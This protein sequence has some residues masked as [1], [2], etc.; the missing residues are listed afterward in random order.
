M[1]QWLQFF[2]IPGCLKVQMGHFTLLM[3]AI[4]HQAQQTH[5][6]QNCVR[7][8]CWMRKTQLVPL[9]FHSL[10]SGV[11]KAPGS[12]TCGGQN[13]TANHTSVQKMSAN[14]DKLLKCWPFYS[15]N[16]LG[17]VH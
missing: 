14:E 4:H 12:L 7:V 10:D 3:I 11:K 8:R 2:I 6:Q 9:H 13:C 16:L 1:P 15:E 5:E 17:T